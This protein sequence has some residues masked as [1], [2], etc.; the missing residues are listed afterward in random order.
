MRNGAARRVGVKWAGGELRR[1]QARLSMPASKLK[2]HYDVIV[3]G[4]GYGGGVA[5]SRLARCGRKVAVL[6]RGREFMPGD[7]PESVTSASAETQMMARMGAS[8]RQR[9]CSTCASARTSTC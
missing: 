6:E 4:S 5:A 7:F 9:L 1:M 3:V 2:S 8:A